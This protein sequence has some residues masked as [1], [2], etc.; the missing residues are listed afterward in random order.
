MLT[1]G[2]PDYRLRLAL[3]PLCLCLVALL[4]LARVHWYEQTPWKGGGFGMFSTVDTRG[5]R[6]LRLFLVHDDE[7]LSI[8]VPSPMKKLSRELRAAPDQ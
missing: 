6:F 2:S 7:R 8:D 5:A 4:Q 3:A 1:P